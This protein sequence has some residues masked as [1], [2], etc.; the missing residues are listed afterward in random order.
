LIAG[1]IQS[2]DPWQDIEAAIRDACGAAFAIESRA[3]AGGG[4]INE[5]HVVRGRGLVFFVKLNTAERLPMFEAEAAGLREIARSNTV[6][7]PR[8]LCHGASAGTS[9]IALE[10]LELRG[11]SR[12][13]MEELGRALAAMH[14]CGAEQFGWHR[15]NTIGATPQVNT[16]DADWVTFWRRRRLGFQLALAGENGHRG[17]LLA[18]GERLL[19]RM[20]VFFSG[21]EPR[22]SLL[23]GDLWSGNAAFMRDG[24]PVLFDPAVYYGDREADLAMTELFGGFSADFYRAYDEVTPRAPG[25]ATRR[26]LYNLYH[27]LNHLN[28]FG[29]GYRAQAERMIEALLSES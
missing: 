20:P 16:S 5:C 19:D 17:R 26:Q 7:V 23:H 28:L 3:A 15:D 22:P 24:T 13:G 21:H 10:Y 8:P 14:G 18:L 11:A 9:W 6:R 2:M 4:C 27:V 29:G 12:R 1:F 25:Y